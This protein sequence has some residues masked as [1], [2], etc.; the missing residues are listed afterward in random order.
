MELQ[1]IKERENV[2]EIVRFLQELREEITTAFEQ[3]EGEFFFKKKEWNYQGGGGGEMSILRGKVFEKAAVNWSGVYGD[4]LPLSEKQESF[5]ATG[6]SLITHMVNPKMPTVHMNLRYIETEKTFWFGGGYDLTPMGASF[7]EDAIHFH[8]I[9]KEALDRHDPS[10]YPQFSENARKYFYIPHRQ[11]ERGIGGIFFDHYNTFDFERDYAMWQ[12]VGRSF[13][14]AILPIY[15]S[16]IGSPFTQEEKQEQKKLRG[17][18]VEFNLVYDRGTRFGFAACKGDQ[19]NV[20]AI[21][22]SLPPEASW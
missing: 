20:E 7:P 5:F 3:L 8:R 6:I 22:S 2:R 9:A 10:L 16:R 21:L 18:Y 11:K 12:E 13:L 4:A 1:S 15:Y 17:H 14:P 19:G